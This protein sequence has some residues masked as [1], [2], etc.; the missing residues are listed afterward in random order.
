LF[1]IVDIIGVDESMKR[2]QKALQ[3]IAEKS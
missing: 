1:D 2:I 3:L